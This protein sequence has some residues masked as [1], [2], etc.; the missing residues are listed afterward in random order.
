VNLKTAAPGSCPVAVF[1][2]SGVDG[3]GAWPFSC[4]LP[5]P[6]DAAPTAR[7]LHPVTFSED[8]PRA[9]PASYARRPIGTG[10]YTYVIVQPG[11]TPPADSK[12]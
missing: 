11:C 12:Q 2:C 7:G 9:L 10:V 6:R 3:N 8:K 5:L 4:L 1:S